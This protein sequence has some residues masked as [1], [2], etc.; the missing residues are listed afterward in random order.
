[1]KAEECLALGLC[2]YIVKNGQSRQKGEELAHK[3]AR[4]PK[5]CVQ[6]DRGVCLCSRGSFNDRGIETRVV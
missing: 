1:M 5:I 2:E 6:A 3:I 4:F